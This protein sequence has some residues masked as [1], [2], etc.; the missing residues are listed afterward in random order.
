MSHDAAEGHVW[1]SGPDVA[2]VQVD[3]QGPCCHLPICRCSLVVLW[4]E[5]VLMFMGCAAAG[6]CYLDGLCFC[7]GP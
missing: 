3:V 4:P 2:R 6:G 7:L 5:S 1:V